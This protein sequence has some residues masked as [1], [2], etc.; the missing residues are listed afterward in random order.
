MAR[1]ATAWTVVGRL[2]IRRVAARGLVSVPGGS[3]PAITRVAHLVA[4]SRRAALGRREEHVGPQRITGFAYSRR[5]AGRA[6]DLR[7]L[8]M[9]RGIPR[10]VVRPVGRGRHDGMQGVRG[11]N[12]L[13]ST[14]HNASAGHPLRAIGSRA[15]TG[16]RRTVRRRCPP[17]RGRP[18]TRRLAQ[19][20]SVWH[21]AGWPGG[22]DVGT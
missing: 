18:P 17:S 5:V 7:S 9:C 3:P 11:S 1:C 19:A 13:S 10:T 20:V 16:R 4:C 6:L 8:A 15:P 14:R 21:A 2:P 22:A 12:P